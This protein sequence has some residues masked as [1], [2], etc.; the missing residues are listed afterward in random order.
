MK[1]INLV[2]ILLLVAI[3][4]S[5]Y[6]FANN[7]NNLDSN[8]ASKNICISTTPTDSTKDRGDDTKKDNS[9]DGDDSDRDKEANS[10]ISPGEWA[11]II[12]ASITAIAVVTSSIIS[13][14]LSW[15]TN[16]KLAIIQKQGVKMATANILVSKRLEVYP[17]LH[18]LTDKL[19][20]SI[21]YYKKHTKDSSFIKKEIKS[22]YDGMSEWDA[23]YC[24][25][26][27]DVLTNN[28]GTLRK[29]LEEKKA[30]QDSKIRNEDLDW[31]YDRLLYIE[32]SLKEELAI[33]FTEF[34]INKEKTE[35]DK[36]ELEYLQFISVFF[37]TDDNITSCERELIEH[38]R[39]S[40]GIKEERAKELEATL[41]K[42]RVSTDEKR[43]LDLYLCYIKKG[44]INE[45][46]RKKLRKAAN[47]IG[48]TLKREEEIETIA[49]N[50]MQTE[51]N[52][53]K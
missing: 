16:R 4:N 36:K 48:I 43:Y 15:K 11:T 8:L 5:H 47:D 27:S 34:E 7:A 52:T 30:W 19:G 39:E 33:F 21:R 26:A 38:K 45:I 12:A 1:K 24:I 10:P 51:N 23:N 20:A 37:E 22:F 44:C 40:L 13:S 9:Q 42:S 49:K 35:K 17:K 32:K 6:T 50:L 53:N 31:I 18:I 28:I 3:V 41:S 14:I 46:D 25:F 2:L 29:R